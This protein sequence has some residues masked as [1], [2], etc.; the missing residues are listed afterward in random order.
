IYLA[1]KELKHAN[2]V[3]PCLIFRTRKEIHENI[4]VDYV[5]IDEMDLSKYENFLYDLRK[6]KGLTLDQAKQLV[7]QPNYLASLMVKLGEADGEICGIQYSTKDTLK[8]ALQ[9]IKTAPG[10]KLVTSA[11]VLEKGEEAYVFGDCAINIYPDAEQ[12]ANITLMISKFA[13]EIAGIEDLKV[14]MLSYST[15]GS[16]AGESVDKVKRAYEIVQADPQ[17]KDYEIF[18]EI[19]FDASFVPAVMHKKAK[20]L[21]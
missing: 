4:D 21:S 9:I 12:L 8:P 2:I 17:S 15:A 7:R 6:A 13:K 19:Q 16:G 3:N 10:A 11:F 1:A 18:G 5:V 20:A 14:A